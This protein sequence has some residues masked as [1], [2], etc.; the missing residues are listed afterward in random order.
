MLRRG[1]GA[2]T[3]P[4][5]PRSPGVRYPLNS[6]T[7][8]DSPRL[9][10][11]SASASASVR[12]PCS[13][14]LFRRSIQLFLQ[15]IERSRQEPADRCM[16]DAGRVAY[17]LIRQALCAKRDQQPV[18]C[19]ERPNRVQNRMR[20][21]KTVRRLERAARVAFAYPGKPTTASS[22]SVTTRVGGHGIQPATGVGELSALSQMFDQARERILNNILCRLR[23]VQHRER[24]PIQPARVL[25]EQR[26]DCRGQSLR[27]LRHRMDRGICRHE[28]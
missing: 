22:L 17:L 21:V 28:R 14:V 11:Q 13:S 9:V 20:V 5:D 16:T 15:T 3:V 24:Q 6:V 12:G 4:R 8:E 23:I 18:A 2:P 25:L 27:G 10:V 19:R 1:S 26:R 7:C